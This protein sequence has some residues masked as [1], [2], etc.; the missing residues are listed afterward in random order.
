MEECNGGR[1]IPLEGGRP[2][3]LE[4]RFI[5]DIDA[6]HDGEPR[7]REEMGGMSLDSGILRGAEELGGGRRIRASFP[8][9]G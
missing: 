4:T 5:G 8:C 1:C 7:A 6:R 9:I 3:P 2:P